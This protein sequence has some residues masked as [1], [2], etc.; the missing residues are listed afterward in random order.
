MYGQVVNDEADERSR[1][2]WVLASHKDV[3]GREWD[4][5]YH[6]VESGE[7]GGGV[8]GGD[9]VD[10]GLLGG[11]GGEGPFGVVDEPEGHVD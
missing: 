4:E 9:V 1:R 6:D 7:A 3:A 8:K 2:R 11:G 10:E 5:I